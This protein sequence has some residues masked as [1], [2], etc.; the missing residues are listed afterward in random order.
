MFAEGV[1][2]YVG[3][4]AAGEDQGGAF[5]EG[6]GADDDRSGDVEQRGQ[7]VDDVAGVM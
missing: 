7:G 2:G 5:G 4:E 1:D 6:E 3:G